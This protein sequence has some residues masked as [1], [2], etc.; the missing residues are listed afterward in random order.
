MGAAGFLSNPDYYPFALA[1][2]VALLISYDLLVEPRNK[3]LLLISYVATAVYSFMVGRF[4]F[5]GHQLDGVGLGLM[6]LALPIL[7]V[8]TLLIFFRESKS[9]SARGGSRV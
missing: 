5:D 2:L 9:G 4:F 8:V 3:R 6:V 7:L 1:S